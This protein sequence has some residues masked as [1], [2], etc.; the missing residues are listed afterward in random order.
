MNKA[1]EFWFK[2]CCIVCFQMSIISD[3]L[4]RLEINEEKQAGQ[5][6]VMAFVFC[7]FAHIQYIFPTIEKE[8]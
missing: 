7:M 3:I 6:A 2:L 4:L 8:K 5:W 1:L